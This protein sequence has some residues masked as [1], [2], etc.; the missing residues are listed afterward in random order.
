MMIYTGDIFPAWKG[1]LF[2]G[3]GVRGGVP[4]TGGLERVVLADNMGGVR[5]ETLL[6]DLHQ[7]VRD[8]VQGPDGLIYVLTDGPENAVLRIAPVKVP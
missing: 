4:G 3:S 7:R 5:R 1:N 6:T 2:V 8:V